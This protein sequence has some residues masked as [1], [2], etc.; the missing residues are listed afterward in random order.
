MWKGCGWFH[1][2]PH[3]TIA[4]LHHLGRQKGAEARAKTRPCQCPRT[5]GA[6]MGGGKQDGE[7]GG[8]TGKSGT[9]VVVK[10]KDGGMR[11]GEGGGRKMARA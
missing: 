2:L 7:M 10:K 8:K 6:M 5:A 11:G 1:H 9:P 4:G 3:L